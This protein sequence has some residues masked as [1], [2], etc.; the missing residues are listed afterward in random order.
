LVE[1]LPA[2]VPPL[3]G[4]LVS[5]VSWTDCDWPDFRVT[6]LAEK[7]QFTAA[8]SERH[9]KPM[10]SAKPLLELRLIV[11]VVFCDETRV[12]DAGLTATPKPMGVAEKL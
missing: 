12:M 5:I 6:E 7:W 9:P 3:R 2:T 4:K 8:G 10:L 11:T 1:P